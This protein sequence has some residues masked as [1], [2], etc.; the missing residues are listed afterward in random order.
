MVNLSPRDI[1]SFIQRH[2]INT[3]SDESLEDNEYEITH[4]NYVDI[5]VDCQIVTTHGHPINRLPIQF[6]N[7]DGD[8]SVQSIGLETLENSPLVVNGDFNCSKNRL[9]DL[10]D[11]TDEVKG[12]FICASNPLRNLKGCDD[13]SYL[14]CRDCSLTTLDGLGNVHAVVALDNPLKTLKDLPLAVKDL[15]ISYSPELAILGALSVAYLRIYDASGNPVT[16]LENVIRPFLNATPL[17]LKK[18]QF[19]CAYA[20]TKAGYSSNA[21][22]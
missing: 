10:L 9:K 5:F 18:A 19:Q 7:I 2:V 17:N 13:Y 3:I 4:G 22:I 15:E 6:G 12:S 16:E 14:D 1:R 8:F 11:A 20:L 21:R